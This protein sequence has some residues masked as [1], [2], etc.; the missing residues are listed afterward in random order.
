MLSKKDTSKLEDLEKEMNK[1]KEVVD[2]MQEQMDE[3]RLAKEKFE[4]DQADSSERIGEVKKE[5]DEVDKQK[6]G[7]EKSLKKQEK[8]LDELK[9]KGKNDEKQMKDLMK[10]HGEWINVEKKFFGKKG[11]DYDFEKLKYVPAKN[12]LQ[13]LVEDQKILAKGFN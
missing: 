1:Q 7:Q 12:K 3:K 8:E 6:R 2:K 5:S 4:Q 13:K 9:D 11:S 10:Q